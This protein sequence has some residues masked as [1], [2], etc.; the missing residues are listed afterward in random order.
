MERISPAI[1]AGLK[2]IRGS[3]GSGTL[4]AVARLSRS[5][6]LHPIETVVNPKQLVVRESD[7]IGAKRVGPAVI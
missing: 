2:H 5:D 4:L 6:A 1:H 3:D 7:H